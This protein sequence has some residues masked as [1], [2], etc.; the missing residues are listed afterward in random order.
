VSE[1]RV[2]LL[3]SVD[4][5]VAALPT[6]GADAAIVHLAQMYA[7]QIDRAAAMAGSAAKLAREVREEH[8]DESAL[9]ERVQALAAKVSERDTLDRLG[10]RLHA[11]LVELGASPKARSVKGAPAK[12]KGAST[13]SGL[14]G[15]LAVGQ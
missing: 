14:R 11:A 2:P 9:Y 1:D 7:A 12:P 10:A 3:E 8:G 5:T 13:L 4:A 6:E 15:G